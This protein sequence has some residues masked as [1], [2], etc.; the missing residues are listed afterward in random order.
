MKKLSLILLILISIFIFSSCDKKE[1]NKISIIATNYVGYDFAKNICKD[2][3]TTVSML[4][5]PGAEIHGKP[6]TKDI[7]KILDLQFIL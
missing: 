3:D 6:S 1:N 2:T 7:I 5:K 4:L